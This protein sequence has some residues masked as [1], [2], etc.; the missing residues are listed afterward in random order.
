MLKVEIECKFLQIDHDAMREK[1]KKAGAKCVQPMRLMRRSILDFEDG[2]L[3]T[4]DGHLRVRDEGD[5]ITATY[6]VFNER[7]VDGAHEIETTVG[8]YATTVALFCQIGLII[9]SEQES[10]RETWELDDCEIVLDEWPWIAPY[11][12][13]EGP[14]KEA[15]QTVAKKLGLNW[16]DAV[17]GG[18]TRV[19]RAEFDIP[20]RVSVGECRVIS[21]DGQPPQHWKR[22][23]RTLPEL[24]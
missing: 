17:Y 22:R 24:S 3:D 18:V 8:D 9:K 4:E 20:E 10:K 23:S 1:L 21:F 6:K 11:M 2:R 19:Y 14:S 16:S 15:I 5:K 13:I 7:T 12:E